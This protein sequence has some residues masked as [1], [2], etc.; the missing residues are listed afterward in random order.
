MIIPLGNIF[1][2]VKTATT[3]KYPV[4]SIKEG[5][6]NILQVYSPGTHHPN[7]SNLSCIL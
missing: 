7:K 6:E 1:T 2:F 5:S 4:Y 3:N